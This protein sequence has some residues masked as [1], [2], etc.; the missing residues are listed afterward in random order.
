MIA[1]TKVFENNEE[2]ESWQ[3]EEMRKITSIQPIF[4]GL[5][6]DQ[7]ETS[8]SAETNY[9]IFVIYVKED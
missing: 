9:S 5:E 4:K 6:A 8:I 7:T 1:S 2:F 3:K